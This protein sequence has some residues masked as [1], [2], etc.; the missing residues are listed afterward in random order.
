MVGLNLKHNADNGTRLACVKL[1]V[2]CNR[3][4][5]KSLF[6]ELERVAFSA[7]V[8]TG[9]DE[10]TPAAID[11]GFLKTIPSV[12]C[13]VH[14]IQIVGQRQNV[15]PVIKEIQPIKDKPEVRVLV[16]FPI[17]IKKDKD[18]AGALATEFGELVDIELEPAQRELN[19]VDGGSSA[20]PSVVVKSGR[21]GNPEPVAAG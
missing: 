13:E 15:Q 19:L 9:G 20:N 21:F 16:E 3:D 1:A 4:R 12:I 6:P 7:L 14:E 18:L 8:E 5:I 2:N 11:F 10:E 17:L